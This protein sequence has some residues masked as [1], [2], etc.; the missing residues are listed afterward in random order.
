MSPKELLYI[1]D[2]L[3]HEHCLHALSDERASQLGSSELQQLARRLSEEHQ[4]RFDRM[5]SLLK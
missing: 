3:G 5:F 4:Q 2:V 1:E